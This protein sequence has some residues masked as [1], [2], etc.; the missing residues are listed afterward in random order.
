MRTFALVV[1][2]AIATSCSDTPEAA[3]EARAAPAGGGPIVVELFQSQGCSSCPPANANL[4]ALA[5]RPEVIALS[6]AVTYWDYLGWKDTFARAAYT[7]R[8]RA[9]H[10]SG[11]SDGVYTPQVVINGAKALVGANRAGL[12][13]AVARAGPLRGGPAIARD[14][15]G[16]S[17][18]AGSGGPASVLVVTYDPRERR[19]PVKAGEN[20]GRTLPHRNIVVDLREA[21]VWTGKPLRVAAPG[22]KDPALRRAVLLQK[23][24]GGP[25]LA[26]AKL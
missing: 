23:G 26:A 25:I 14:G 6:Y 5:S 24:A 1:A 18:A 12:R 19:V 7:E 16:V 2:V 13:R 3:A 21:G 17:I 10:R 9:Y 15:D 22:A 4:N 20:T 8:Q 11:R